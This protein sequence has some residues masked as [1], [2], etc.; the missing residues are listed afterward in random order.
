[1]ERLWDRTGTPTV[2][3]HRGGANEAPENSA[4][5]FS[6]MND[7]GFRYMETDVHA[8]KDGVVVIMHDPL[9]DRTTSG[10][11]AVSSLVWEELQELEDESGHRPLRLEEVLEQFPD[12]IFNVDLKHDDVVRPFIRLL[13]KNDYLERIL[14]ASFSESRLRRMRRAVPGISTSL[15][16]SAILRLWMASKLRGRARVE[17]L[18]GVPGRERGVACVQVPEFY[19]HTQLVDGSFIDAVHEKGLAIHVWTV[20]DEEDMKRLLDLGV[21]GIITDEPSLAQRI[22]TAR[23]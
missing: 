20:N 8:S 4:E 19:R 12:M 14:V 7:A 15:G 21:D 3:A 6:L 10:S 13:N 23:G 18:R 5:A 9:L 11:G 16:T 1:M 22:I 17:A 2:I